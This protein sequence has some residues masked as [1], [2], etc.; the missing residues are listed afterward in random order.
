MQWLLAAVIAAVIA[1]FVLQ[2][3][4]D[5]KA[6]RN[7][8]PRASTGKKVATFFFL[9]IFMVVVFYWMMGC[10]SDGA[11]DSKGGAEVLKGSMPQASMT[12]PKL[13]KRLLETHMIKGIREDVEVGNA[14]F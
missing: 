7:K 14:P 13:D 5:A 10:T 11:G 12:T 4:D 8:M 3:M 9:L 2:S 1:F 6:D